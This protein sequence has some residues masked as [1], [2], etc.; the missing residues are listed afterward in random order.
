MKRGEIPYFHP[1]YWP[2]TRAPITNRLNRLDWFG[3]MKKDY[4]KAANAL[5]SIR[6]MNDFRRCSRELVKRFGER[7]VKRP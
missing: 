4:D 7:H 1:D 5:M 6:E 2:S 3:D